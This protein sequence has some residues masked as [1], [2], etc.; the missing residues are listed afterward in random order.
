MEKKKAKEFHIDSFEKLF[1]V[2]TPENI[3]RLSIDLFKWFI[4]SQKMIEQIKEKHPKET[5]DKLNSEIA[6]CTF[7]WVDDYKNDII[8]VDL[9]NR[10]TGEVIKKRF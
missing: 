6:K 9:H 1:N 3:D 10:Q 4:Y 5:K 7:L 2:A 8:G